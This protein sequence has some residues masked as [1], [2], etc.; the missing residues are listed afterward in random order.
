MDVL[1]EPTLIRMLDKVEAALDQ[2]DSYRHDAT[3]LAA[4][5]VR[6]IPSIDIDELCSH[7]ETAELRET[8]LGYKRS[9]RKKKTQ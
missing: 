2:R 9:K 5:L 8:L 3:Y 1:D 4:F 6:T 7:L